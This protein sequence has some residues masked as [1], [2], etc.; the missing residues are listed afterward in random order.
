MSFAR[1]SFF[2]LT[3]PDPTPYV[4]TALEE[5]AQRAFRV[6]PSSWLGDMD[7]QAAANDSQTHTIVT[8][9]THTC[10]Y[11]HKEENTGSCLRTTSK[12]LLVA[13]VPYCTARCSLRHFSLFDF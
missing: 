5:R 2:T 3:Q 6:L 4:R 12:V 1:W 10:Q 7:G 8:S 13:C 11:I 9:N